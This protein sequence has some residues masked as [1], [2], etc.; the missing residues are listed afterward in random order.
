MRMQVA[1]AIAVVLAAGNAPAEELLPYRASG[2]R[3]L[4]VPWGDQLG[5]DFF[6]PTF[7]DSFWPVGNAAFGTL[8]SSHCPLLET[9]QTNWMINTDLLLRREFS[10]VANDPVTLFWTVDNDAAIYV[11]GALVTQVVDG[12]CPILDEFTTSVPP[13]LIVNG[14]NALAVK[15]HDWG[16]V[17]YFDIRIEGTLPPVSTQDTSW[18]R[19]KD[20]YR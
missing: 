15:C 8:G 9:V 19:V 20:L 13:S 5:Q 6:N 16:V 4:E 1:S 2:W 7:D 11:N 17:C 18:G 3:F 14:T 12:Y 10:A